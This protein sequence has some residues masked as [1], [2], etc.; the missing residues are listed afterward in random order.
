M[1]IRPFVG[2]SMFIAVLASLSLVHCA[3][4]AEMGAPTHSAVLTVDTSNPGIEI[5]QCCGVF[6]E[7]INYAAE[8]AT[9]SWLG[10]DRL[11]FAQAGGMGPVAQAG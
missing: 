9:L 6:Y 8:R 2:L 7:D 10:I 4:A 11:S 1:R 5:S 3:F